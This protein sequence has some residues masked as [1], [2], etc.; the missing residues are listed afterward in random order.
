MGYFD[1]L[2]PSSG[3]IVR[4]PF[5]KTS[6][7]IIHIISLFL[8][9]R[10]LLDALNKR[11]F[12]SRNLSRM[13]IIVSRCLRSCHSFDEFSTGRN[14][15]KPNRLYGCDHARYRH[16]R[17]SFWSSSYMLL[18]LQNIR[19]REKCFLL[20]NDKLQISPSFS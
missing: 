7:L 3:S 10:T 6:L 11:V 1:P 17:F 9:H 12:A 2:H 19:H 14:T 5:K 16:S 4:S 8:R 20:L 15:H 13:L 18:R